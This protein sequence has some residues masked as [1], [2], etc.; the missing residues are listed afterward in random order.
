MFCRALLEVIGTRMSRTREAIDLY[1][2]KTLLHHSSDIESLRNLVHSTIQKLV[3][4]QLITV[5]DSHEYDPTLLGQA[6]VAS[7]LTPEDGIF[8]YKELRK[9][10][11]AFVMDG[12]MHVL[13]NFTPINIQ[14]EVDWQI[15]QNEMEGLDESGLRA[16]TFVG[17]KPAMINKLLVPSKFFHCLPVY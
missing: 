11:Q 13:Y 1:V 14:N 4:K 8:V 15:F 12:D 9:A 17:I 3:E 5:S 6:I 2:Q 10:L 7:S 16:M